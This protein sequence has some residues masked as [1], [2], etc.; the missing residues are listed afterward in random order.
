MESAKT[1]PVF[2]V[3]GKADV[4]CAALEEALEKAS[5]VALACVVRED[6]NGWKLADLAIE[7]FLTQF[8]N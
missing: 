2:L 5:G 3:F 8:V 4:R 1:L 6:C 7:E